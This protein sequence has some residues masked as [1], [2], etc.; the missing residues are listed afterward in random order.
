MKKLYFILPLLV[1]SLGLTAQEIIWEENFDDGAPD[2]WTAVDLD[3]DGFNWFVG[4]FGRNGTACY[5]SASWD[6]NAGPLTPNNALLTDLIDL[7]GETTVTFNWWVYAQ[8]QTWA[9]EK[10][11]L[12]LTYGSTQDDID[13]GV[14]LFE[15]VIGS[16]GD[17]VWLERSVDLSAYADDLFFLAFVHYDVTDQFRMN[18]DDVSLVRP[19]GVDVG[20]TGVSSPSN[21]GSCE[22]S[23][24]ENI[25]VDLF[26]FGGTEMTGFELS[27]SINGAAPVVETYTGTLGI[28][29]ADTYTF[30]TPA[31]L[32][33]SGDYDIEVSVSAA[34]DT[35]D[36]N[37]NGAQSV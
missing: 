4:N 3:G 24:S 17:Q 33:A 8:D 29:S 28:S 21:A 13:N 19:A 26:N 35:D 22:L 18:I 25:T 30:S 5:N 16:T 1:L 10:Y 9:N 36:S 15:E 12:V 31:D 6:Q 7:T 11:K 34:D 14:V 20:I 32:S 37:D 2:T 27:Y 23:T